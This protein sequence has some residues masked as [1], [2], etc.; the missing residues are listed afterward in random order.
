MILKSAKNYLLVFLTIFMY[1]FFFVFIAGDQNQV[2]GSLKKRHSCY[3]TLTFS[4][5]AKSSYQ[6]GCKSDDN[7]YYSDTSTTSTRT[8][9]TES[10]EYY[11]KYEHD[12]VPV[13]DDSSFNDHSFSEDNDIIS[14]DKKDSITNSDLDKLEM[15][16]LS[17]MSQELQT[18]DDDV[19]SL[20][21][22]IKLFRTTVQQIFDNFYSNMQ[23]FELY[24]KRFNEILEKNKEDSFPEMEE[25]IKDM[26]QS[27]G[28]SKSFISNKQL[29]APSRREIENSDCKINVADTKDR[30]A[31]KCLNSTVETF[32][33]DNYLTDSTLDDGSSKFNSD[34]ITEETYNI[35][36]LGTPSL[37]IKMTNRDMH[38][39]IKIRDKHLGAIENQLASAENIKKIA[40]KKLQIQN[41][42]MLRHEPTSKDKDIPV[43]IASAKK[44]IHLNEDF[45][46]EDKEES[47]FFIF[48]ICNY[49]CRK[50]RKNI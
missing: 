9:G 43:K 15:K 17:K 19:N 35:Y 6:G 40:A 47:K 42:A 12:E 14:G 26:I 5:S 25:F 36:L 39:E 11:K 10:R 4:C 41:Y 33:N 1:N 8:K 22:N 24:K 3:T 32:V 16:I 28:S 34:A 13:K 21:S 44:N 37:E 7:I 20:E 50:F 49:I 18:D 30:D 27:I 45:T 46:C 38:S 2:A 48:K 23:D 31:T 29:E